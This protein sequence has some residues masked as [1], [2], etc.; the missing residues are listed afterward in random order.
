M[1][2]TYP[3]FD[4]RLSR[5]SPAYR[6]GVEHEEREG[7]RALL[8]SLDDLLAW[9]VEVGGEPEYLDRL[10]AL[11]RARDEH[12]LAVV[13]QFL[14]MGLLPAPWAHS[15]DPPSVTRRRRYCSDYDAV[16]ESRLSEVRWT[17]RSDRATYEA[18]LRTL[19]ADPHPVTR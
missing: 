5:H 6:A 9:G 7:R 4:F 10:R 18:L 1:R 12:A 16:Y 11:A 2:S 8:D 14:N 3:Q 19:F 15:A 17:L 13:A